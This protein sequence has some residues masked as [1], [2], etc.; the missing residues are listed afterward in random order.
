MDFQTPALQNLNNCN[1]KMTCDRQLEKDVKSIPINPDEQSK[2]EN[3]QNVFYG[4]EFEFLRSPLPVDGS[5]PRLEMDDVEKID[6]INSEELMDYNV[7]GRT[8]DNP[9]VFSLSNLDLS[10]HAQAMEQ[11]RIE[12]DLNR[13]NTI[14]MAQNIL[15]ED[16]VPPHIQTL[17]PEELASPLD[18]NSSMV[19]RKNDSAE[20]SFLPELDRNFQHYDTNIMSSER[21]KGELYSKLDASVSINEGD[22]RLLDGNGNLAHPILEKNA[23]QQGYYFKYNAAEHNQNYFENKMPKDSLKVQTTSIETFSLGNASDREIQ[24]FLLRAD[25]GVSGVLEVV[26]QSNYGSHVEPY[27]QRDHQKLVA[28][29]L[30]LAPQNAKRIA[31]QATFQMRRDSFDSFE[32]QLDPPELGKVIIGIEG[33]DGGLTVSIHSDRYDTSSLIRRNISE[34]EREFLQLGFHDLSFSFSSGKNPSH[35]EAASAS[36]T[37]YIIDKDTLAPNDE[38][39]VEKIGEEKWMDMR[40]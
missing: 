9:N 37:D 38:D 10:L 12:T 8:K 7:S 26:K 6:V 11:G 39:P 21:I 3:F 28:N 40:L 23:L 1:I 32:I 25:D 27:L 22:A 2:R 36:K 33:K 19:D 14:N 16:Q 13:S 4:S 24:E 31:E 20:A 29:G 5:L 35:S 17:Q 18:G 30:I 15:P 34:L